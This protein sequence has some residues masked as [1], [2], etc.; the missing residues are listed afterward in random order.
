M[1]EQLV[2]AIAEVI[3]EQLVSAIAIVIAV[4]S[5]IF[6]YKANEFNKTHQEASLEKDLIIHISSKRKFFLEFQKMYID[7]EL[8]STDKKEQILIDIMNSSMEEYL[9]SLDY[10]CDT[11]LKGAINKESFEKNFSDEIE[12]VGNNENFASIIYS[13]KSNKYVSLK[14]VLQF[15][16]TRK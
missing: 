6:S 11:Y 5:L 9:N 16:E 3:I 12:S 10:T 1:I 2:S 13:E 14:K 8:C 15:I 4:I 7:S